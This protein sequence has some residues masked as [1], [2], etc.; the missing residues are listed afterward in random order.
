MM[1]LG[2]GLLL[3]PLFWLA[4]CGNSPAPVEETPV[5]EAP[6]APAK[7]PI[8][9]GWGQAKRQRQA[10][11]SWELRGR[12]GVQTAE[13]GG[14]FDLNWR[15]S[16]DEYSIRLLA[17]MGRGVMQIAGDSR[18]ATVRQ[19]D[20]KSRIIDD[21][22]AL[23]ES[24]LGV[25]LPVSALRDWVRG[26]PAHELS[27]GARHW[28]ADGLLDTLEQDGWHV[29]LSN[30]LGTPALPHK[31]HVTRTDDDELDVRLALRRWL[32]DEVRP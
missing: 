25:P 30:Y 4:A 10:I 17:P 18:S 16:G 1:R 19:A 7:P 14:S 8:P 26:L 20:G 27:P 12:L 5:V 22:G 11:R 21:P 6:A 32:V 3:A 13:T 24:V 29:E 28:N 23:F 15:Q 2:R 9:P 31:I